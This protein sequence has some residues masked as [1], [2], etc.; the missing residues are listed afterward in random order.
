MRKTLALT[1]AAL[2]LTATLTGCGSSSAGAGAGDTIED[3]TLTVGLSPD[4]P[5][6]EYLDEDSKKLVGADVDLVNELAKRLDLEVKF[7]QQKFDQLI[8]S[9]RTE[10]VD[11]IFSGMSDTVERQKTVDF[12]DYYNSIGRF[13]TTGANAS[14]YASDDK[15]CGTNIAVSEKTDY[16]MK[17]QEFSKDTC[18]GAGLEPVKIIATDSG[19]AARLQLDQGRADLA[20]Q[21]AENLGFFEKQNPGKYVMVGNSVTELPFGA[22]VQ[23]DNSALAEKVEK[24]F[25]E[26]YDDGTTE[27]ILAEYGI[28]AG[29]MEPEIN[30]VT[31]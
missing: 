4:F 2:V 22:A 26:M 3:G 18:E 15:F 21:G 11:I 10:R 28:E 31:E 29:L 19:S 30:G 14:K 12:I 6:M 9:V 27:K 17:L 16:Y 23:K 13:Y 5:P 8:N 24:T 25:Q 7:E 1:G 20:I